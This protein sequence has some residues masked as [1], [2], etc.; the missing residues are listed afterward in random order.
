MNVL[1]ACMCAT[2]ACLVPSEVSRWRQVPWN[3]SHTCLRAPCMLRTMH[4]GSSLLLSVSVEIHVC[5][6]VAS[7][8]DSVVFSSFHRWLF[9]TSLPFLF[10]EKVVQRMR[11]QAYSVTVLLAICLLRVINCFLFLIQFPGCQHCHQSFPSSQLFL[12]LPIKNN[13]KHPI[14]K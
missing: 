14:Y 12:K 11:H 7:G 4:V 6:L 1:P 13:E 3:W 2:H 9:P 8:D 5:H 10:K